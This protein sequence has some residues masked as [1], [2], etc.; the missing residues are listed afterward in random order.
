MKVKAQNE[1]TSLDEDLNLFD[2]VEWEFMNVVETHEENFEFFLDVPDADDNIRR[3]VAKN[4]VPIVALILVVAV[5]IVWL[6]ST[7]VTKRDNNYSDLQTSLTTKQEIQYVDGEE[8]GGEKLISINQVLASYFNTLQLKTDYASLNHVCYNDSIFYTNYDDALNKMESSM[9]VYDCKVR[10]LSEFG[11]Y[12]KLNKIQKIVENEGTYYVYAEVTIP[13]KDDVYDYIHTYSYN[14][15]KF[16]TNNEVN[17][18]NIAKF[19]LDTMET[20]SMPTSTNVICIEVVEDDKSF[21]ILDDSE[22]YSICD[23]AYS[24]SV[25]QISRILGNNMSDESF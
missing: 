25:T 23:T 9:D 12:M 15:T 19:L 7:V 10:A 16:F 20:N 5:Q 3:T 4:I 13:S 17:Q 8:V 2:E 1:F 11:S 21:S 6:L 22:I 24:Y 18:Q 14:L